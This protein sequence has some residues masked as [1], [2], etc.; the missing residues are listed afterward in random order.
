MERTSVIP[1]CFSAAESS[2]FKRTKMVIKSNVRVDFEEIFLSMNWR[3]TLYRLDIYSR[4]TL[5]RLDIYW[6]RTLYRLDIY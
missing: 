6:H 2:A 5:Y 3:R 1:Y 4:R